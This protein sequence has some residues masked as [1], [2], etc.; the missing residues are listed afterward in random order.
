[1]LHRFHEL[2]VLGANERNNKEESWRNRAS[3]GYL[4]EQVGWIARLVFP[5]F[6]HISTL[7]AHCKLTRS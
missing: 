3:Q 1:M 7:R 4:M 5:P 6:R 2:D